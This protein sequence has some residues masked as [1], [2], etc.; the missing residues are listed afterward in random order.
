MNNFN[1][2]LR[3][4]QLNVLL[5]SG[6]L[7]LITL[8]HPGLTTPIRVAA[9]TAQVISRQA[10]FVPFNFSFNVDNQIIEINIADPIMKKLLKQYNRFSVLMEIVDPSDTDTV[11]DSQNFNN[12]LVKTN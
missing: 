4:S 2:D 3:L 6:Y 10:T 12:I 7:V 1:L 5:S 11:I 9:A 8:H